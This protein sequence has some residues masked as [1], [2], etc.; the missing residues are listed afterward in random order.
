M[1]KLTVIFSGVDLFKERI[2]D[3]VFSKSSLIKLLVSLVF[4][5]AINLLIGVGTIIMRYNLIRMIINN[6]EV[7]LSKAYQESKNYVLSI[8]GLKLMFLGIYLAPLLVFFAIGFAYKKLLLLMIFMLILVWL[9]TRFVFLFTYAILFLKTKKGIINIIKESLNYSKNN[10]KH[11]ILTG[12]I[13]SFV[14]FLIVA[15]LNLVSKS[16][17]LDLASLSALA[18]IYFIIKTLADITLIIW[19]NLFVFKNY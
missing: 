7:S 13:T 11:V 3:I 5:A 2:K 18:V 8:I 6:E 1:N 16:L 10:K 19:H 12:V 17:T 14:S 4:L 15:I 9:A